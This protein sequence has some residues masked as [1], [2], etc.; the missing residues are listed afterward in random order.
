MIVGKARSLP[1][2]AAPETWLSSRL[3]YKQWTRLERL[4]RD[5][6]S[7]L[8]LKFVIYGQKFFYNIGTGAIFTKLFC[9]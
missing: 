3:A 9:A 1:Y 5:K 7:S 6:H 2:N 8:I 4:A